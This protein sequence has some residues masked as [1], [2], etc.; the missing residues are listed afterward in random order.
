M[1]G[2]YFPV[3]RDSK[4]K[5]AINFL[6]WGNAVHDCIPRCVPKVELVKVT[7]P[8]DSRS[9]H[10]SLTQDAEAVLKVR[11]FPKPSIFVCM[12]ISV[13]MMGIWLFR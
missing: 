6:V 8:Q 13:V 12:Q 9:Q 3:A 1:E 11:Q 2:D 7:T 5:H 10:E 4:I